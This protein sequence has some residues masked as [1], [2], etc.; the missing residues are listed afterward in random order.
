MGQSVRYKQCQVQNDKVYEYDQ[1]TYFAEADY[2]V[3]LCNHQNC[4]RRP[5]WLT[6][7]HFI[8]WAD[9]M[10]LKND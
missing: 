6:C 10:M 7:G 9:K 5:K 1:L 3:Y 8:T 4:G 2:Q